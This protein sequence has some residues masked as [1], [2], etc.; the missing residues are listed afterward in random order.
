MPMIV[1]GAD[2]PTGR[3][4]LDGLA[5]EGEIRAF[6]TDTEEALRLRAAGLKVALGDVSDDSHVELAAWGCFSAVFVTEAA[7]DDRVRSFAP[8]PAT[9]LRGWA[10]AVSTA[11]VQRVIWVGGPAVP[12]TDVTEVAVVDGEAPDVADRVAALDEAQ[13]I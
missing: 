13:S 9:V 4:I 6:V 3:Q 7:T 2:T 8:D 1:V 12:D 5:R 10:R 11:Q